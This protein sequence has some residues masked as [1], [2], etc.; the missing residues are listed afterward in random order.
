[1]IRS[2]SRFSRRLAVSALAIL[3]SCRPAALPTAVGTLEITPIDLAP[4][5]PARVVRVKVQEGQQVKAGDTV[6][7]LTQ[8]GLNDQVGEA[9]ARVASA[10]AQVDELDRGSR[11]EEITKS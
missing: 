6:A 11:P 2:M 4:M 10:Q 9:R 3:A 1:M 7:V 8:A 5:V